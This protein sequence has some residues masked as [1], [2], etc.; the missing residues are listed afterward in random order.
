MAS[1]QSQRKERDRRSSGKNSEL[2]SVSK[3]WTT[4]EL[5]RLK[6]RYL[7]GETGPSIAAQ[8][9]RTVDAVHHKVKQL[10]LRSPR[11]ISDSDKR[12]IRKLHRQ[13]KSAREI[14]AELHR[15]EKSIYHQLSN[16]KLRSERTYTR[17]EIRQIRELHAQHVLP[18]EI[19]RILERPAPGL[20]RKMGKLGLFVRRF[21]KAEQR[22]LKRLKRQGLTAR[23]IAVQLPGRDVESIRGK[24]GRLGLADKKCQQA[25]KKGLVRRF[26]AEQ[27][28]KFCEVLRNLTEGEA[29]VP[30]HEIML[31]WNK[32][33][34]PNGYPEVSRDKVEYWL[35]KLRLPIVTGKAVKRLS[36]KAHQRRCRLRVVTLHRNRELAEVAEIEKL[37]EL[38][39]EILT[40]R[41]KPPM[42]F[43]PR[44]DTSEG[45]WPVTPD[46][47]YFH[48]N[49]FGES[50][51]R[52]ESCIVC[53]KRRR[54]KLTALKANGATPEEIKRWMRMDNRLSLERR[55]ELGISKKVKRT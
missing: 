39:S 21:S 4:G 26:S 25:A 29:P 22:T 32:K 27:Q 37:R 19:A 17:K 15:T 38:R 5:R 46:F 13:G 54:R 36:A 47:F 28:Q 7:A 3:P 43:C 48:R 41:K 24:L 51:A 23:Q 11:A 42:V 1:K 8:L 33:I 2:K 44:C 34:A 12:R 16:M 6:T 10:K 49:S 31:L 35:T 55:R 53:H 18:D 20:K 40:K 9:G 45:A 52:T 30:V 14:A 50:I